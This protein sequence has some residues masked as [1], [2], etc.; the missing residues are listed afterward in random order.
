MKTFLFAALLSIALSAAARA[1][2]V[3]GIVLPFKA[4]S[5]SSP[6]LQDVIKDIEVDEGDQ[7]KQGQV[8]AHLLND[9]EKL[10][11]QRTEN[12][13]KRA[14]F[15]YDGMKKLTDE[16]VASEDN[17]IEKETDLQAAKL[18]YQLAQVELDEKTIKSPLSGIIVQRY[19][20]PGEAVDRTEKMF[21]IVNIDQVYI[22]FDLQPGLIEKL[23]VGDKIPIHF[24]A[25]NG[26]LQQ[27]EAAVSFIAPVI[28][29]ASGTYRVKLLL[30]NPNHEISAGM[31]GEADFTKPIRTAAAAQ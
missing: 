13:I 27:Y 28:D 8:L 3:Q 25:H 29:A 6:V 12:L 11:V 9:R 15:E 4:V 26:G 19:K 31:R 30:D 7:V 16:K 20:E 5:V 22:R 10:E 18:E 23:E 1:D 21:D 2:D 17:L 14:Q 24:P